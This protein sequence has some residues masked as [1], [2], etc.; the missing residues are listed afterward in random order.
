MARRAFSGAWGTRGGVLSQEKTQ[1]SVPRIRAECSGSCWMERQA[2]VR[3]AGYGGPR[4]AVE[5]E[6]VWAS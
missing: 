4:D 1:R 5:G 6:V 3:I 2:V